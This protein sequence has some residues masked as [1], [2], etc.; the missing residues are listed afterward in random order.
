MVKLNFFLASS[1]FTPI[2]KILVRTLQYCKFFQGSILQYFRPSLIYHLSLKPLFCLSFVCRFTEVLLFCQSVRRKLPSQGLVY[3]LNVETEKHIQT[4]NT[5]IPR[6][7]ELRFS[8]HSV[9]RSECIPNI[10]MLYFNNY[11]LEHMFLVR[12]RNASSD[13]SYMSP[14]FMFEKIKR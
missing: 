13:V 5:V 9:I 8:K 14:K 2:F 4:I 1:I 3:Y 10:F 11:L 12:K 6:K 7:F